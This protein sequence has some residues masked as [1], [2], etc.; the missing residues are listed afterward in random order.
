MISMAL[1]IIPK[2]SSYNRKLMRQNPATATEIAGFCVL[3]KTNTS[4]RC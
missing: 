3:S 1:R 4:L 2:S